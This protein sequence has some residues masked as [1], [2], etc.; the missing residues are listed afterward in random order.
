MTEATFVFLR[1]TEAID[2]GLR[3]AGT[4]LPEDPQDLVF[5]NMELR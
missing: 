4:K 1:I 3:I 5:L 2:V